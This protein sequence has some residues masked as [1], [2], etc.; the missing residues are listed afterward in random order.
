MRVL[1]TGPAGDGSASIAAAG[2]PRPGRAPGVNRSVAQGTLVVLTDTAMTQGCPGRPDS[3]DALFDSAESWMRIFGRDLPCAAL[4]IG[5]DAGGR[6]RLVLAVCGDGGSRGAHGS[7]SAADDAV[8]AET[9]PC[10]VV[11]F[12]G[13]D[14][15]D[16]AAGGHDA[17]AELLREVGSWI[18]RNPDFA[19][20]AVQMAHDPTGRPQAVLVGDGLTSAAPERVPRSADRRTRR[21][22]AALRPAQSPDAASPAR[23]S[24]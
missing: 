4:Q 10:T 3:E 5:F 13:P 2:S 12:T 1:A 14:F 19:C 6:R 23:T 21:A 16:V 11:T 24:A 22:A 17:E 7:W 20:E 18:R 15:Y 9:F 8:E